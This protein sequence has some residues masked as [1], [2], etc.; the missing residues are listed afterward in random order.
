M[1]LYYTPGACSM[2]THIVLTELGYTF[3]LEKTDTAKATT[4]SGI[5]YRTINPNGYVPALETDDGDIL[6]ENPAILQFL[7][8]VA[9]DA[10]L[11]PANGTFE[12]TRLHELLNYL[13]SELH[14]AYSPFFSGR[15]LEPQERDAAAAKLARRVAAIDR[16]L[17]DGREHLLGGAFGIADAYA[18]VLLNWSSGIGFDLSPWPRVVAFVARIGRRPAVRKALAAEGQGPVELAS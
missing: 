16:R 7:A 8:D 12:R 15:E 18:F 17:A 5:D 11:A 1:K 6:T 9:P 3:Q 4:E 10:G 13:S 2:A 14:K